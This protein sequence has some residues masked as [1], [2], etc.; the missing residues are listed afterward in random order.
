MSETK[1]PGCAVWALLT[2]LMSMI[3]AISGLRLTTNSLASAPTQPPPII[4]ET[5]V[6]QETDTYFTVENNQIS[7]GYSQNLGT[8]CYYEMVG[9]VLDLSGKP[10]TKFI[11]HIRM[12]EIEDTITEEGY[13]YPGENGYAHDGPSGWGTVLPTAPVRYEIWLITKTGGE[14]LS[15]HIL[16]KP[17]DCEH[18]EARINFIQVKALPTDLP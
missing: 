2:I 17:H 18:N 8:P 7:Y 14:E 13:A 10:F 9:R 3:F 1:N 6:P 15:P 4:I 11:V 12:V 16:V 5:V